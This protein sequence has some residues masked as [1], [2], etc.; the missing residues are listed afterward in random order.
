MSAINDQILTRRTAAMLILVGGAAFCAFLTIAVVIDPADRTVIGPSSYSR[1]AVGHAGLAA[2]LREAGH[3][4]R[5]NRSRLGRGIGPQDVLLVLEPDLGTHTVA[6]L[7]R[8]VE[9]KHRVLVALPKRGPATAF[10]GTPRGW[11]ADA[12]PLPKNDPG[13]V[14][15]GIVV[16]ADIQRPEVDQPW[17]D[18][19]GMGT[20]AIDD[21]IQLVSSTQLQP[22]VSRSDGILAGAAKGVGDSQ[23]VV[24]ADPDVAANHGLHR[25]DNARLVLGLVE[26]LAPSP[27]TTI[28]FD[29]TLHGFAIV[30]SLP[31]L[32][33]APPF[34]A[35][36]LLVLGAVAITVWR[37]TV[38]FGAPGPSGDGYP[39]FGSGHETLLGNAGRLLAAGD[40]AVY[41]ADRYGTVSLDEAARRLHLG[42]QGLRG[43]TDRGT[44]LRS[45]L[46]A[47]AERRGVRTRLPDPSTRPLARARQHFDWMEEMFGGSGTNRDN[48]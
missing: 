1:S 9:G 48:R 13:K 43:D 40:H 26:R 25:G 21:G 38:R 37:A 18:P 23:I 10:P 41:V 33:M 22:L 17:N 39:R 32:L 44:G 45:V 27:N 31:L 6:D 35:A 3:D 30:P 4:V 12:T 42:G 20:P 34:L 14:A 8:L 16:P 19:L 36:T 47:I 24:L 28:H 46:E 15:R 11:I 5:V 29:E 2:L 7:Q